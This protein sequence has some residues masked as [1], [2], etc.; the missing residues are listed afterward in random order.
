MPADIVSVDCYPVPTQ[1]VTTVSDR[2]DDL[3]G[4]VDSQKPIQVVLQTY[5]G[6]KSRM[7]TPEEVRCMTWLSI[8]HGARSQAYYSYYEGANP[9]CLYGDKLLWSYMRIIN[10]ELMLMK[11]FI[12]ASPSSSAI[13]WLEPGHRFFPAAS[14][15][16]PMPGGGQQGKLPGKRPIH[17]SG[18]Q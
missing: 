8:N 9:H 7:P 1:P 12:L 10:N 5:A 17:Y 3:A 16:N 13:S 11:D 18:F 4:A 15:W 14:Q 6:S 2:L